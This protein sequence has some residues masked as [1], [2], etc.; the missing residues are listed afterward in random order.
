VAAAKPIQ[1]H[2][3][4]ARPPGAGDL[5]LAAVLL[6]L[7]GLGVFLAGRLPS[8]P[9]PPEEI[10]EM[11]EAPP[12]PPVEAKEP[13]KPPPPPPARTPPPQVRTEAPPPVFGL[14]ADETSDAGDMAA[15]T[16]NT[17]AA[18]PDSVVRAAPPPLYAEPV[19]LDRAPGFLKQVVA[20]YP[21]WARD[22]GVEAVV[23]VWVTIDA[24]G[25]VTET[26]LQRGAGKDFDAAALRAA[27]AS[28][29]QPL[30]KDGARLPSRFVVTYDFKLEG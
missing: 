12:P 29:F 19:E 13:P 7:L 16:G 23:R 22:Q 8:A 11:A 25:R 21:E 5:S 30:V 27:R 28:L 15:A 2:M 3:P 18:K 9:H 6:F 10:L 14:Q 17:L 4:L 20:E 24:E 1:M 26:R